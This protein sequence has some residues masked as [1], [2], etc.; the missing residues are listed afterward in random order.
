MV[1]NVHYCLHFHTD[2]KSEHHQKG[3]GWGGWVISV[4][5]FASLMLM[6]KTFKPQM[7]STKLTNCADCH[8]FL[9]CSQFWVIKVYFGRLAGLMMWIN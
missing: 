6:N 2:V 8:G 1:H 4:L 7:L 9:R 3:R 5:I